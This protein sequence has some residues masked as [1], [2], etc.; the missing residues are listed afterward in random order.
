MCFFKYFEASHLEPNKTFSTFKS[1]I[2]RK[3]A[4]KK[5]TEISPG[6]NLVDALASMTDAIL[7]RGTCVSST[8]LN[9]PIWNKESL[10][11]QGIFSVAGCIPF[12]NY[13]KS[14]QKTLC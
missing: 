5:L 6:N 4:F 3:Y 8:Q 10:P 12:K 14:H 9:R 11:P 7:W 1:L 13:L 2:Y